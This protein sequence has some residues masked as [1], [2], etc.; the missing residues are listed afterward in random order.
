MPAAARI[1][2]PTIGE[3]GTDNMHKYSGAILRVL[4]ILAVII[5]DVSGASRER[6][7]L[8]ANRRFHKGDPPGVDSKSLLYDVR[9][10]ARAPGE[11]PTEFTGA[12]DKVGPATHPIL[13]P[14]ILPTGNRFIKVKSDFDGG[15][16]H[17]DL[18]HDWAIE[19]PGEIVAT[20]NGDPP[21]QVGERD[22][23]NLRALAE[24]LAALL[25]CA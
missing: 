6:I 1:G 15:W 25:F 13:K 18:P 17:V 22:A 24:Q 4:A 11:G 20:D 19:G 14:Y 2:R 3:S 23:F 10:E 5:A 8:N 16:K 21:F 9:P 12:V 7:L